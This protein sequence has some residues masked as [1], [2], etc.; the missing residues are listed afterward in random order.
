MEDQEKVILIE[1]GSVSA[2]KGEMNISVLSFQKE[3]KDT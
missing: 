1:Q 2:I 3:K